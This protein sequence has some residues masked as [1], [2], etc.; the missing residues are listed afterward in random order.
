MNFIDKFN[1]MQSEIIKLRAPGVLSD[2]E[3]AAIMSQ[4]DS[5]GLVTVQTESGKRINCSFVMSCLPNMTVGAIALI[6]RDSVSNK[7]VIL[8]IINSYDLP[9]E[10]LDD[11][12]EMEFTHPRIASDLYQLAIGDD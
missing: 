5:Y 3:I 9:T 7:G 2:F 12:D 6:V 8:G 10:G 11:P 1:L 4:P